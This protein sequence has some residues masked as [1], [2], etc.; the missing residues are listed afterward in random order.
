MQLKANWFFWGLTGIVI[1]RLFSMAAVPLMDPSEPR[2]AEIARLMVETG[3]WITP[4]F[5][6][7]VPF[8]GKPPLSFWSQALGMRILGESEFAVRLPSFLAMVAL[9]ALLYRATSILFGRETARWATLIVSTMLLPQIAAGAVLTDPFFALGIT[10]SMLAFIVAPTMPRNFWRYGF[11]I[12]LAIGQLSKGPLAFVLVGLVVIPWLAIYRERTVHLTVLPWF[13]GTL[14]MLALTVPWYVC[15]E[16]KTP[17]FLQY[18][19]VGEH[20]LRFVDAGWQGDLYGTAHKSPL[21]SIWWQWLLASFPWG[22][23]GVLL[24]VWVGASAS[25]RA[26]A[27][28]V[29]KSPVVGY[30]VLWAIAAPVFFT[31]SG[32]VLW[33][34]VLPSLP[35]LALLFSIYVRVFFAVGNAPVSRI[36]IVAGVLVPIVAISIGVL[37]LTVPTTLTTEKQLVAVARSQMSEGKKLYF[38]DSRPFSARFYSDGKAELIALG[39]L[40]KLVLQKGESAIVAIPK[41]KESSIGGSV[42]A[43]LVEMYKSRRYTL[44]RLNG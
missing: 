23:T 3:D 28:E 14:V 2:Y 38:V 30:L 15:A 8:W 41:R 1:A 20:F 13:A 36:L 40:E 26:K 22:I 33:T 18:F 25:R 9:A 19:L 5:E 44:Y 16:I 4:W 21:G 10:Y 43:R 37:S 32:N 7:G 29:H 27:F 11:F 35:A 42:R 34:Y 6:P 17:G 39:E 31:F 12:G 24:A